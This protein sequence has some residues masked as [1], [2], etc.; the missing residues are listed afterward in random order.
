MKNALFDVYLTK[1]CKDIPLRK[2]ICQGDKLQLCELAQLF[3]VSHPFNDLD[4]INLS[5]LKTLFH[6]FML[7]VYLICS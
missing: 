7:T 6:L 4:L 5:T 2:S 3:F 1:L